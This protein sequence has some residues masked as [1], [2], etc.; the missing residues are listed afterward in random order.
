MNVFFLLSSSVEL[1]RQ[2]S[3]SLRIPF[4]IIKG[5]Y[6]NILSK[7][8]KFTSVCELEKSHTLSKMFFSV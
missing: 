8:T 7:D 5:M 4:D 6:L 3:Q 1:N 2:P